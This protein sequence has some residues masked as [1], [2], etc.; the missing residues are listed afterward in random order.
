MWWLVILMCKHPNVGA[1][2]MPCNTFNKVI[3]RDLE[4]IKKKFRR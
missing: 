2:Y 3:E 1:I 4:D